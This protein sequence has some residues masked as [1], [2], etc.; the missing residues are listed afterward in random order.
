MSATSTTWGTSVPESHI[1]VA[2]SLRT[3]WLQ[4]STSF[5]VGGLLPCAKRQTP[6]RCHGRFFRNANRQDMTQQPQLYAYPLEGAD[7]EANAVTDDY[8]R[9][10]DE[11][12]VDLGGALDVLLCSAAKKSEYPVYQC[13]RQQLN[14]V[15]ERC[16]IDGSAFVDRER[17]HHAM[18]LVQRQLHLHLCSH[19]RYP[20]TVRTR[21]LAVE[22]TTR[23]SWC[24]NTRKHKHATGRDPTQSGKPLGFLVAWLQKG[25]WCCSDPSLRTSCKVFCFSK[26]AP[27]DGCFRKTEPDAD[28]FSKTHG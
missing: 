25:Q 16:F 18:V 19:G 11:V 17:P 22:R 26:Q 21:F 9:T 5:K 28:N 3:T 23:H 4:S 14:H 12:P 13:T 24:K 15:A 2:A 1:T 20:S 27:R 8:R 10:V 7:L 6:T